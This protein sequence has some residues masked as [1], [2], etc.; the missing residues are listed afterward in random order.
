MASDLRKS[1]IGIARHPEKR[2][3]GS[4]SPGRWIQTMIKRPSRHENSGRLRVEHLELICR[5]ARDDEVEAHDQRLKRRTA[6]DL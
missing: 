5:H 4:M 2:C 6:I 1:Q 3:V